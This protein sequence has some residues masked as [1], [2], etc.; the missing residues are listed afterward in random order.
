M[1]TTSLATF[2]T[3]VTFNDQ[4]ND[5]IPPMWAWGGQLRRMGCFFHSVLWHC[6]HGDR[7]GIPLVKTWVLVCLVVT[8]W[9]EF[10]CLP[11]PAPPCSNKIQNGGIRVPAYWG[12]PGKRSSWMSVQCRPYFQ[13]WPNENQICFTAGTQPQIVQ[14][15]HDG[16]LTQKFA[17]LPRPKIMSA[18]LTQYSGKSYGL[19]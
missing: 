4:D 10:A 3:T 1:L 6:W 7:K 16:P 13:Q 5:G 8:T 15:A 12:C 17:T 11:A 9:L 18:S 14:V 19:S 2:P